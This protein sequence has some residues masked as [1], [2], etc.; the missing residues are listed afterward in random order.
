[1]GDKRLWHWNEL[2]KL[3]IKYL[4][5]QWDYG[6]EWINKQNWIIHELYYSSG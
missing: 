4:K 3:M 5:I 1:M 2:Q 6:N